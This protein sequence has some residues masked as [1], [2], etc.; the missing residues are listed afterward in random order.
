MRISPARV[1]RARGPRYKLEGCRCRDCGYAFYPPKLA[2]PK[3][4][5]KNVEKVQL[6][7]KGKVVTWSIQYTVPEGFRSKA[8]IVAAIVE[9]ENGVKVLGVLTDVDPSQVR[10]GMEVEAMLRRIVE[11]GDEGLIIYGVKFVPTS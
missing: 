5:S 4:G 10:E 9:L 1:W 7:T 8:P 11:D 3:C 6:P 2:C